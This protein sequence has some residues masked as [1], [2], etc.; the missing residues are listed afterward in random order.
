MLWRM[1]E[2]LLGFFSANAA[3]FLG[4]TTSLANRMASAEEV[5]RLEQYL[6]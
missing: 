4:L 5:T 1:P 6:L 3:Q 2:K